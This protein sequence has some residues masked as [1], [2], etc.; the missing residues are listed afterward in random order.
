MIP[1]TK[2]AAK[3]SLKYQFTDFVSEKILS[4]GE[5]TDTFLLAIQS[6]SEVKLD[7]GNIWALEDMYM[8]VPAGAFIIEVTEKSQKKYA[9]DCE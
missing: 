8:D 9:S 6:V 1:R 3:S 5:L 4:S 2:P 7:D